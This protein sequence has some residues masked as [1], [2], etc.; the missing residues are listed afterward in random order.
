MITRLAEYE[1]ERKAAL[2]HARDAKEKIKAFDSLRSDYRHEMTQ[3]RAKLVRPLKVSYVNLAFSSFMAIIVGAN[4]ASGMYNRAMPYL[5]ALILGYGLSFL[6]FIGGGIFMTQH[7]WEAERSVLTDPKMHRRLVVEAW[8]AVITFLV[9]GVMGSLI[10]PV[11]LPGQNVKIPTIDVVIWTVLSFGLAVIQT[12]ACIATARRAWPP[13]REAMLK[14]E[15]QERQSGVSVS[16]L[17]ILEGRYATAENS[18]ESGKKEV[19]ELQKLKKDLEC[20]ARKRKNQIE[21]LQAKLTAHLSNGFSVNKSPAKRLA[22][23]PVNRASSKPFGSANQNLTPPQKR[24]GYE[25]NVREEAEYINDKHNASWHKDD[26]DD[27]DDGLVDA[28]VR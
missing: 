1:L 12:L 19:R 9:I 10:A 14:I 25:R 27:F 15:A 24:D 6:L 22:D 16:G 5:Q 26:D 18:I 23:Y 17:D 20:F 4:W 28:N 3:S 7:F 13:V 8:M 2:M 21:Q 11:G